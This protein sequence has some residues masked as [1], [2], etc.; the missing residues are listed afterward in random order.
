MSTSNKSYREHTPKVNRYLH[1]IEQLIGNRGRTPSPINSKTK[2]P[3]KT[4]TLD[5]YLKYEFTFKILHNFFDKKD[6]VEM[7]HF[8]NNLRVFEQHKV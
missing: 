4:Q 2:K 7:R 8:F 1:R 3:M 5:Y 6:K